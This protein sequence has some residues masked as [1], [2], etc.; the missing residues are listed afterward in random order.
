[1]RV[2]PQVVPEGRV[3][4]RLECDGSDDCGCECV[5]HRRCGAVMRNAK[6]RCGRRRGHRTEHRTRAAVEYGNELARRRLA[7]VP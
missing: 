1:M 7:R 2:V 6:E 3:S 4:H 5:C